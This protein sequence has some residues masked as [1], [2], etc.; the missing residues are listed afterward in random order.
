MLNG[1]AIEGIL[2]SS[3]RWCVRINSIRDI[4]AHVN[5]TDSINNANYNTFSGN[6]PM[7][8]F[9]CFLAIVVMAISYTVAADKVKSVSVDQTVPEFVV[10]NLQGK[11]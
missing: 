7:T 8:R 11:S 5:T 1:S 6:S 9:V 2:S 10:K 3:D 4:P